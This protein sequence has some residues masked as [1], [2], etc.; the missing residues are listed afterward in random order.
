MSENNYSALLEI[1][2]EFQKLNDNIIKFMAFLEAKQPHQEY[3]TR[4]EEEIVTAATKG[5]DIIFKGA[6]KLPKSTKKIASETHKISG[7][8]C[9]QCGGHISWD[10]RPERKLPL[11]VDENGRIVGTGDCPEWEGEN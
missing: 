5:K 7:T 6:K 11:H 8:T 2:R 3:N 4:V 9:N 1:V 10:M